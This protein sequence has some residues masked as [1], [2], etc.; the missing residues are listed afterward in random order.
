M[1]QSRSCSPELDEIIAEIGEIIENN[2]SDNDENEQEKPQE[3]AQPEQ[4][5]IPVS[6]KRRQNRYN[7]HCSRTSG[8][9]IIVTQQLMNH[10]DAKDRRMESC[11]ERH[12]LE[13]SYL[14]ETRDCNSVVNMPY[15]LATR[16]TKEQLVARIRSHWR[17][18]REKRRLTRPSH[19]RVHSRR[20][21]RRSRSRLR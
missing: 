21:N 20:S 14:L 6:N 5:W 8:L 1:S 11:E 12:M 18:E 15:Y 19:V 17:K 10:R 13:Q 4:E 16:K 3:K 7:C 2:Y 9:S